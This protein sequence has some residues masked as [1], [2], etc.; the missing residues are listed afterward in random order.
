M[1][2][3][4]IN[5]IAFLPLILFLGQN[6]RTRRPRHGNKASQARGRDTPPGPGIESNTTHAP[7]LLD[8]Y[9]CQIRS[10]ERARKGYRK[11]IGSMASGCFCLV[12]SDAARAPGIYVFAPDRSLTSGWPSPAPV[13]LCGQQWT[14][15]ARSV[16]LWWCEPL[17]ERAVAVATR[18]AVT[19]K[20]RPV[21]RTSH[22][23]MN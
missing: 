2:T 8:Q 16:V 4:H 11:P 19:S 10:P 14:D 7:C 6:N 3:R 5:C 15:A 17:T 9:C 13:I 18:V 22:D 12:D 23:L 21:L 20:L 1:H